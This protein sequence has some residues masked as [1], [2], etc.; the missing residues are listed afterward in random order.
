MKQNRIL[1]ITSWSLQEGLIQSS[2]LPY[3]SII[4]KLDSG[5]QLYLVTEEKEAWEKNKK[6]EAAADLKSQG[7]TWQPQT[8]HR[9]GI[10]KLVAALSDFV[11]LWW[12]VVSKRI[13]H[14]HC[15][16]TPAG[17][18]GYL[19]SV[20]TG[21]KLVIDSYEPHAE[22]MVE[23][24]TWNKT[25]FAFKLLWWF[26]KKQSSRA[27]YCLSAASGMEIYAHEKY[28]VDLKEWSVRPTCVDMQLFEYNEQ[29]ANDIRER[30]GWQDKIV[31]VYAGKLGGIY[32][33]KEVFQFFK[34]SYEYW[35]DR[36][37]ILLLSPS[38][39]E[40]INKACDE[41]CL[42][43]HLIHLQKVPFEKVPN[44]LS[45]ADFAITPVKP[46]PT[47][48]YCSPIKD[49]EYWA[50]G[51]PVVITANISDDSSIIEKHEAGAVLNSLDNQEYKKAISVIDNLLKGDRGVLRKRIRALAQ[52]YR[53]YDIAK[54]AYDEVYGVSSKAISTT[55]EAQH[56][57]YKVGV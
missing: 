20:L 44:Y 27:S 46:V 4:H 2:T 47:K 8:Y 26:E 23:N 12:F 28:D 13:T 48:R 24:G 31:C 35:G 36:F 7:I 57:E 11:G 9:F 41:V 50:I 56:A 37:C 21:K 1:V 17:S 6:E 19:L 32:L 42:P 5:A 52:T 53:N 38:S 55:D 51:L 16:C 43:Q 54:K 34:A 39:Q 25:G 15:F 45:A 49:G 3:L 30:L 40:E 10:K 14:I 29:W 18:V 33:D 22:S